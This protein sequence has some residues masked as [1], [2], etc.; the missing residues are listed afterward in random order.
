[1]NFVV[2]L[3]SNLSCNIINLWIDLK[4]VARLDAA[5]CV[6]EL[7]PTLLD[8]LSSTKCVIES[9]TDFSSDS[10]L[11]RRIK[12]TYFL[13][14]RSAIEKPGIQYMEKLG[15]RVSTIVSE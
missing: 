11:K 3:P 2:C 5:F 8:L 10:L 13:I 15:S 9:E 1:M 12:V 7:R 14:P 4:V 6:Q